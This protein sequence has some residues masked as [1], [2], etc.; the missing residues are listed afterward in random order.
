MAMTPERMKDLGGGGAFPP[1][2]QSAQQV[3]MNFMQIFS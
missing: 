2:A 1:S 3:N